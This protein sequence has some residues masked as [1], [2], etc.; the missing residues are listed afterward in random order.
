MVVNLADVGTATALTGLG[1]ILIATAIE[2]SSLNRLVLKMYRGPE[3]S[4]EA[5]GATARPAKVDV[6]IAGAF[7]LLL[8]ATTVAIAP[9][10]EHLRGIA[11]QVSDVHG[12]VATVLPETIIENP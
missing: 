11:H 7:G 2:A 6:A 10:T 9:V 5:P 4:A 3:A 1:A 12:Y 8:L